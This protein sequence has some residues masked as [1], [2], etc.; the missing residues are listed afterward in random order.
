MS[1]IR[2]KR[3]FPQNI[4]LKNIIPTSVSYPECVFVCFSGVSLSDEVCFLWCSV[5]KEVCYLEL[6]KELQIISRYKQS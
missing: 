1:L 6:R 4:P 5:L 2:Y 3:S